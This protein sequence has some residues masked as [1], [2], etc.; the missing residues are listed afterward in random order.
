METPSFTFRLARV[1]ALR[2]RAEDQAREQLARELALRL[3]GEAMLRA[4]A[5]TVCAAR[6]TGRRTAVG[7]SASGVDLLGAQQWIERAER[8]R[9]EAALELDR[10]DAEVA[11]RRGALAAASRERQVI[12]RLEERR[13]E[14]HE[15][16]AARMAQIAL[17]EIALAVHRRAREAA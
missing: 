5:E 16:E 6:E 4:A 9:R 8:E 13:R 10:R 3:R 17:D 1:K 15:R 11:A 14:E 2:E 12:T 7:R